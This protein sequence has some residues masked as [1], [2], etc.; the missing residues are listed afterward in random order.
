MAHSPREYLRRIWFDTVVY[1]PEMIR[2]L[3]D[4]VGVSQ[5]VVG[6]DYPYD[7]GDYRVHELIEAVQGLTADERAKILGG[8]AVE[9]LGLS[10]VLR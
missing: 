9:L 10:R 1:Q 6:T 4:V 8:N 2:H 7:M 3:I 5:V